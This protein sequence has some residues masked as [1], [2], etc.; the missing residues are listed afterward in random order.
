V[1]RKLRHEPDWVEVTPDTI[2]YRF[3][4]LLARSQPMPSLPERSPDDVALF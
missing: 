3:T 2:T 4:D 1:L